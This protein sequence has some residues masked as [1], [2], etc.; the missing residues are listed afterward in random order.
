LPIRK[1][2][3]NSGCARQ[4]KSYGAL[5]LGAQ[6]LP[7]SGS[8]TDTITTW[9]T[10]KVSVG[11]A[12]LAVA[13]LKRVLPAGLGKPFV[14]PQSA[15][16]A[17]E[18]SATRL[19]G[20]C[21]RQIRVMAGGRKRKEKDMVESSDSKKPKPGKAWASSSSEEEAGPSSAASEGGIHVHPRRIRELK[22]GEI[23]KGPVIYW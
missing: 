16:H 12:R 7:D 22:G 14:T 6:S 10:L 9:S 4:Y 15:W 21:S 13:S 3:Y 18:T 20:F 19:E 2:A 5:G 11:T 23:K 1:L 8:N 17:G